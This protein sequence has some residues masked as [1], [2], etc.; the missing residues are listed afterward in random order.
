MALSS[1]D[2]FGGSRHAD[3][4]DEDYGRRNAYQTGLHQPTRP[5]DKEKTEAELSLNIKKAT[6][7]EETA[8]SESTAAD[9]LARHP[10]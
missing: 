3:P 6:S 10:R 7:P 8:P 5:V 2:R 9:P 1:T 4:D